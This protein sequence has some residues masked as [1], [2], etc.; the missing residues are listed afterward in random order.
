MTD[1]ELNELIDVAVEMWK[2]DRRRFFTHLFRK[3]KANKMQDAFFENVIISTDFLKNFILKRGTTFSFDRVL[4]F[5]LNEDDFR[6]K[7]KKVITKIIKEAEE[8][9]IAMRDAIVSQMGAETRLKN[10]F[11]GR[12]FPQ[13]PVKYKNKK[14]K[15]YGGQGRIRKSETY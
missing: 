1:K 3:I 6:E 8:R 12:F 2:E 5:F 4:S 15:I 7:I 14:E 13:R 11:R 10:F 9:Y